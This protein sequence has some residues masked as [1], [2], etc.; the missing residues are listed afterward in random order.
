MRSI[1]VPAALIELTGLIQQYLLLAKGQGFDIQDIE[2]GVSSGSFFTINQVDSAIRL[3]TD[4]LDDVFD[5]NH[6]FVLYYNQKLAVTDYASQSKGAAYIAVDCSE[7]YRGKHPLNQMDIWLSPESG[8]IHA[9]EVSCALA[10]YF[11]PEQHLSWLLTLLALDFSFEDCLVLARAMLNRETNV[12]RE[13]YF[14]DS[15]CSSVLAQ[16]PCDVAL[17]PK[18][19][20]AYP[21]LGIK[22]LRLL[23]PLSSGF[24]AIPERSLGFYPIVDNVDWI[25]KL[26]GL[27]VKAIQLRIKSTDQ[28]Y[29]EQQVIK[30][31]ELGRLYE[32]QI[33]I[34]DYWQLAIKYGAYGVHL[35]QEDIEKAN[36]DLIQKAGLRLGLSSHGYYEILRVLHIRPSYIAFGPIFESKTKLVNS[37]P[38]GLVRLSLYQ[39]L[40]ES[41]LF[42][43]L[44][45]ARDKP[46]TKCSHYDVG[47]VP[48]VAIGGINV[49]NAESVWQCGVSSLAVVGAITSAQSLHSVVSFFSG[50]TQSKASEAITDD[51]VAA[52]TVGS[53]Y[54]HR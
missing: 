42:Q 8:Q 17:F 20:L 36:L 22:A 4:L 51:A 25:E 24:P 31:I 13:T 15:L 50:L 19:I 16:W 47:A 39:K 49:S 44:E 14:Y 52:Q 6:S 41:H 7:H 30:A 46:K 29:I 32:A 26:L 28:Q 53:V 3:A 35:G 2:L 34:N 10:Q 43:V 40:M 9:Q 27:G 33:F 23:A 38:Q 11:T 54:A 48:T 37:N 5:E 18:P 21:Q 45:Q 1:L 12:S